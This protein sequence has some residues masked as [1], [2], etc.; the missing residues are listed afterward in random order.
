MNKL[1]LS[2]ND[3]G[4]RDTWAPEKILNRRKTIVK[5]FTNRMLRKIIYVD[6]NDQNITENY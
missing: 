1:T 5:I 6:D 3:K 4:E 2:D